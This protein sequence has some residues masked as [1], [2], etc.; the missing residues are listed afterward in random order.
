MVSPG[1]TPVILYL[2]ESMLLRKQSSDTL[3]SVPEVMI[4]ASLDL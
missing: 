1:D 4:L 2:H 3:A